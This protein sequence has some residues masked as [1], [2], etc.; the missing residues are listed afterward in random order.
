MFYNN[1]L[2]LI[3]FFMKNRNI[4]YSDLDSSIDFFRK[5]KGLYSH[6][7]ENTITNIYTSFLTSES[8]AI[9]IGAHLGMHLENFCKI[10][11]Y[12]KILAFEPIPDLC[13]DLVKN[14]AQLDGERIKI[15]NKALSNEE[16]IMDFY[17]YPEAIAE[18]SLFNRQ[19]RMENKGKCIKISVPV[20]KLD[21]YIT[22]FDSC[23][24]IK[25]DAESAE[26][27]ILFGGT[28]FINKFSPVITL[29]FGCTKS[30]EKAELFYWCQKNKYFL[31]DLFCNKF[32]SEDEWMQE[33]PFWDFLLIPQSKYEFIRAMNMQKEFII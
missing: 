23:D 17:I 19:E 30:Q 18:S 15:I 9:D 5:Y 13:N 3:K 31:A 29:E 33:L 14:F 25:I 27:Q 11:K 6:I 32:N 10:I 21:S 24:F 28:D 8:S 1:K 16:K 2:A 22:E 4:V 7:N 20:T 12:G 26:L